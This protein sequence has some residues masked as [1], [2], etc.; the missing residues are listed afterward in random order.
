MLSRELGLWVL[1]TTATQLP[2]GLG[3]KV[4]SVVK[5]TFPLGPSL[6]LKPVYNNM[7]RPELPQKQP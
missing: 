4:S 5:E 6:Q 3:T 7:R 1:I 2:E